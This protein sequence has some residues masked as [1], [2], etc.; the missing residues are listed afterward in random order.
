MIFDCIKN[1]FFIE[2]MKKVAA[3]ANIFVGRIRGDFPVNS[4]LIT[5]KAYMVFACNIYGCT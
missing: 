4:K 3:T 5:Y 1:V 2:N